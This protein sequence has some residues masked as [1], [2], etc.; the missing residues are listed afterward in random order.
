[1]KNL[2][3]ALAIL[4]TT[5]SIA[6]AAGELKK[7]VNSYLEIQ[8]SLAADKFDGI[9]TPAAAIV[10]DAD[11]MGKEGADIVAAAKVLEQASDRKKIRDA[12]GTLST[13]VIAAAKSAGWKDVEGLKLAYCPMI[14]SSWLQ[15]EGRIRNPYYGPMMLECGE[16]RDPKKQDR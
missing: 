3:L 4:S 5:A 13:A 1:M 14:N 16:L 12:F 10:R 15:K 2:V 11:A 6:E 7:V 9:K 8:T